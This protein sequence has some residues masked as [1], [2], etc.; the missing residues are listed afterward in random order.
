MVLLT[1]FDFEFFLVLLWEIF[2]QRERNNF[3][4]HDTFSFAVRLFLSVRDFFFQRQT[5]S[6]SFRLFFGVRFFISAR[7]L[8]FSWDFFF[9]RKT[10]SFSVRLLLLVWVFFFLRENSSNQSEYSW[11]TIQKRFG[12]LC[13]LFLVLW[14]RLFLYSRMKKALIGCV[15]CN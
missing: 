1:I 7:L 2:F 14:T 10:F 11:S 8:I 3:F 15:A 5:F 12:R 13:N 4:Q 6:F 9:Q